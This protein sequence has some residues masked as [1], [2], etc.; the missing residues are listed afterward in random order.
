MRPKTSL[1]GKGKTVSEWRISVDLLNS[2]WHV[3]VITFSE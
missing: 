1:A 3:E 2:L